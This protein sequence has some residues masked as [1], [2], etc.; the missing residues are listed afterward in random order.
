[1]SA[2]M[3][4]I[5][6]ARF[7][8]IGDAGELALDAHLQV[9][10]ELNVG[11]AARHVGGDGDHARHAGLGDDIALPARDSGRSAPD[12]GCP[13]ASACAERVSD[14]SIETVPTSTGWPRSRAF[15]ISSVIASYF[16]RRRTIDLVVLVLAADRHVGRDLDHVEAVD[17]GEFRRLG[18]RRAGHAGELRVQAEIVL[19]R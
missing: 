8:G 11:A 17:L 1:M 9:A 18:H 2:L 16:S 4:S 15:L 6:A 13:S 7:G 12:A 19:D 10:A 5:L 14:F 3:A